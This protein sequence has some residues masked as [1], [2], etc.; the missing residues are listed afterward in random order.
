MKSWRLLLFLATML[1]LS[2]PILA[3]DL[4]IMN[5]IASYIEDS[6]IRTFTIS[7]FCELVDST[8]ATSGVAK[9]EDE[10]DAMSCNTTKDKY[11]MD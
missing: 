10:D 5:K 1:K 11:R 8:L 6:F 4:Q 2:F 7:P 3:R 9:L